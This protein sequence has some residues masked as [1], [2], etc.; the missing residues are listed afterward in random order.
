[1]L[2][3]GGIRHPSQSLPITRVETAAPPSP[4]PPHEL[5]AA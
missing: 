3:Q 1:M 5:S 4:P 2:W